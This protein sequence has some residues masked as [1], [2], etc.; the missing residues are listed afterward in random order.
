[1]DSRNF[2]L[3]TISIATSDFER[4]SLISQFKVFN[5]SIFHVM[6]VSLCSRGIVFCNRY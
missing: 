1:M 5:P 3:T 6:W 4:A 2:F